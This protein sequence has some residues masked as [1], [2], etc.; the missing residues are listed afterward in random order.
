MKLMSIRRMCNFTK[1]L[2][3]VSIWISTLRYLIQQSMEKCSQKFLMY[4]FFQF[5]GMWDFSSFDQWFNSSPL[6][7]KVDFNPGPPEKFFHGIPLNKMYNIWI[8]LPPTSKFGE[9]ILTTKCLCLAKLR[10]CCW[11]VTIN[12]VLFLSGYYKILHF[13]KEEGIQNIF[14]SI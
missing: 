14:L 8:F 6:H 4:Y 7:W 1:A 3:T 10:F 2:Y 9:W 11:E 12:R 13:L 5:Y